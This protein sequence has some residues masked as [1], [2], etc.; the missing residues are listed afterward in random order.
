MAILTQSKAPAGHWYRVDGSPMH[1]LVTS[2][3][4]GE[5]PTTLSDARRLGLFPSVTGILSV[6]AK[7]GL[8]RWKLQQV[9]LAAL[10]HP[11]QMAESE[12]YWC[13]RVQSAAFEQVELAANLGTQIHWAL[14]LAMDGR[15]YPEAMRP[16]VEP[17]LAWKQKTGIQIM[18]REV[19]L[20]NRENGFAGTADVIFRYGRNGIGILDYKTRKT[21]PG[22]AVQAYDNQAMQLAAYGATYWGEFNIRRLLAANVFISTTE[23]GRVAV[24]KHPDPVKDWKAFRLVAALWRYQTGYD[25]RKANQA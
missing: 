18:D 5:R 22:E 3:G 21:K 12:D 13:G 11:K 1:R 24:I 14:E 6:L 9:A 20:V 2:D 7:P 16:Y 23:P 8:E 4:S 15:A 17:V 25:P 19:R 10:R